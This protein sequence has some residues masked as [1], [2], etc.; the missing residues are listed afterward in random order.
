METKLSPAICSPL[1]TVKQLQQKTH[2]TIDIEESYTLTKI[3]N[4]IFFLKYQ[5]S[6]R[7]I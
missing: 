3:P 6:K 2:Q 7:Y 1:V 5:Y 4:V